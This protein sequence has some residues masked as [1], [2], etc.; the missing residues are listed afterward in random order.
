LALTSACSANAQV[1]ITTILLD[2]IFGFGADAVPTPTTP[3]TTV[4]KP[5]SSGDFGSTILGGSVRSGS[6]TRRA[7]AWIEARFSE[8]A[9]TLRPG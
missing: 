5:T 1:I 3:P 8:A 4:P 9:P 2:Q 7:I 6:D